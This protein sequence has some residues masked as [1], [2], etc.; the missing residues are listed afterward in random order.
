MLNTIVQIRAALVVLGS[1]GAQHHIGR[2][3]CEK[4]KIKSEQQEVWSN[5]MN[6]LA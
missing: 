1:V 2:A 3:L 5:Q 4:N 6:N